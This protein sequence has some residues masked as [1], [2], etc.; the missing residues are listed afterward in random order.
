MFILMVM[1]TDVVMRPV[2]CKHQ[3]KVRNI[4]YEDVLAT[5]MKL[6]PIELGCNGLAIIGQFQRLN[7]ESAFSP[8]TAPEACIILLM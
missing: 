7:C 2:T 1:V 6:A 3:L 5:L 4:V 8:K